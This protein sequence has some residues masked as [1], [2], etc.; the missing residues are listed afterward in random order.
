MSTPVLE[1]WF[2]LGDKPQ[3]LGSR[4][5]VCGTYYFPKLQGYCRNPDC[6]SERFE[7]VPLSRSGKLW[8]FT[9]ASYQ[10]PEPYIASAPFQPFGIAAVE[11][12][13]EK[14]VVLGQLATGTEL[15]SLK[16]GL[17]MELVLE[18]LDDGKLTWKWK[19]VRA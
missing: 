19:Q 1:G 6:S 7:E 15:A 11:L 16:A 10:P 5:S 4:C 3:L 12:L 14:M 17:D 18:P 8:S 13:K 9:S 2:T